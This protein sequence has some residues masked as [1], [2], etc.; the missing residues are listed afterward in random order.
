[1]PHTKKNQ[2]EVFTRIKELKGSAWETSWLALDSQNKQVVLTYID[3]EKYKTHYMVT[4]RSEGKTG[5]EAEKIADQ[6]TAH[7]VEEF[8]AR[9]KKAMALDFPYIAKTYKLAYD[10][11]RKQDFMVSEYVDGIPIDK[12]VAGMNAKQIVSLYLNALDA[13]QHIHDEGW[14]HLNIKPR[15]VV[16]ENRKDGHFLAK[17]S[18]PGFLTAKGKT[19]YK[20][21]GTPSTMAPELIVEHKAD[22]R[23]DIYSVGVLLYSAFTNNYPPFK[24]PSVHGGKEKLIRHVKAED[25]PQAPS[26]QG[27]VDGITEEVNE[28]ILKML[29][30][31]PEERFK[32]C[33]AVRKALLKACPEAER[34]V[35]GAGMTIASGINSVPEE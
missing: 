14:L 22:E 12:A 2:G 19:E 35:I 15:L 33:D 10:E 31:N 17:L 25:H 32:S 9:A 27:N 11:E 5:D 21:C 20:M 18:D 1:M 13:L 24:R 30:K 6:K 7:R 16:V 34:D 4:A 8:R 23:S 29:N 28:V 3:A 26:L